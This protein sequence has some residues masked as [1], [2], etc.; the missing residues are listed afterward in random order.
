MIYPMA[1]S[2]TSSPTASP[3][4]ALIPICRDEIVPDRSSLESIFQRLDMDD[5]I[6]CCDEMECS[7]REIGDVISESRKYIGPTTMDAE[8]AF[9]MWQIKG[10]LDPVEVRINLHH[11]KLIEPVQF[12]SYATDRKLARFSEKL[13][14]SLET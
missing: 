1:S 3:P 13:L 2:P 8:I 14:T 9:L 6:S 10:L 12:P 4:T 7:E 5:P 11:T